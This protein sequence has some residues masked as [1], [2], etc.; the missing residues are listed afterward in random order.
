MN[1]KVARVTSENCYEGS[2]RSL[3]IQR[4]RE[5][6]P[7]HQEMARIQLFKMLEAIEKFDDMIEGDILAK[8][9]IFSKKSRKRRR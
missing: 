3:Q 1:G 7:K 5:L 2:S 8:L 4:W 6:P 9:G